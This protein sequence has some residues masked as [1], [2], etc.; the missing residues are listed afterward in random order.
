MLHDYPKLRRCCIS[1]DDLPEKDEDGSY[2]I[3]AN[4]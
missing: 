2:S 1:V 3:A 4:V